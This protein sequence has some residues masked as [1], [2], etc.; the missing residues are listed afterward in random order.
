M[1]LTGFN[2]TRQKITFIHEL[3]DDYLY[4]PYLLFNIIYLV[5]YRRYGLQDANVA[6]I[7]RHDRCP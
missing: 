1:F 6:T 2:T 4:D 3:L 7:G 5:D